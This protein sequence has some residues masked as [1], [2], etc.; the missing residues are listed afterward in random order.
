MH[1]RVLGTLQ[2]LRPFGLRSPISKG[3]MREFGVRQILLD[4]NAY[5]AFKQGE[6]EAVEILRRAQAIGISSIVLGELLS[7]F[8]AGGKEAENRRELS[9]LLQSSR[10]TVISVDQDTSEFYS[11]VY[12][13]LR[14]KM[15]PIPTNDL[16]IA[17][18]A[19][20]HGLAVFS[21]DRHFAEVP[22]L[23]A[24]CRLTDFLP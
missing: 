18:C 10:V 3:S 2:T 4:T 20:Q 19:L 11:V 15:K 9:A 23:I 7:G 21:Y 5:A 17:A 16:W 1:W 6:E 22:G 12:L 24:G 13:G 8:A 14:R